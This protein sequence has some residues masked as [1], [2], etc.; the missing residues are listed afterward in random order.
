MVQYGIVSSSCSS[1]ILS[2]CVNGDFHFKFGGA[3]RVSGSGGD[4]PAISGAV[5]AVVAVVVDFADAEVV[6]AA[7]A[8]DA[9]G[10][11]ADGVAMIS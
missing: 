3:P 7:E 2:A 6:D 5:G 4:S 10:A 11:V 1:T 9:A 8:A